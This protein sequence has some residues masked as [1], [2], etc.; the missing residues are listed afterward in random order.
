MKTDRPAPVPVPAPDEDS[1]LAAEHVLGLLTRSEARAVEAR[2]A[3]D[4][5]FRARHVL[6]TEAFARLG[7][8]IPP[9]DPPADL[10]CRLRQRLFPDESDGWGRRI[11]LVPALV[12]A[13][14]AGGL[15]LTVSGRE[16]GL[17]D[18]TS[19][20][21]A[22]AR[23]V[24]PAATGKGYE[25][26]LRDAGGAAVLRVTFPDH[27]ASLVA[28]R[29]GDAPAAATPV[30]LWLLPESG[31]SVLL[32]PV[33]DAGP[34]H[35]DIPDALPFDLPSIRLVATTAPLDTADP[36]FP[37]DRVVATGTVLSASFDPVL[38]PSD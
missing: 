9:V 2:L 10:D 15:V 11:G 5:A 32:G 38:A 35:F 25:A 18:P 33:L 12:S 1:L 8:P 6:W 13:A 37:A 7:Q 17:P 26:V 27:A 4:P 28:S 29:P 14:I 24:P 23:A 21:P 36:G 20:S 3:G 31:A 34:T 30:W 19:A 22:G 16:G